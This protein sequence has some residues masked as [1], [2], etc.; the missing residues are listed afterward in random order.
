MAAPKPAMR[1]FNF[2]AKPGE[3]QPPPAAAPKP[4]D[5]PQPAQKPA[6]PPVPTYDGGYTA[7]ITALVKKEPPAVVAAPTHSV[8][9][10]PPSQPPPPTPVQPKEDVPPPVKHK[11]PVKAPKKTETPAPV[12]APP[13]PPA[14]PEPEPKPTTPKPANGVKRKQKPPKRDDTSKGENIRASVISDQRADDPPGAH[15]TRIKSEILKIEREEYFAAGME[16][17]VL[18]AAVR[19]ASFSTKEAMVEE[20]LKSASS[21]PFRYGSNNVA[22]GISDSFLC[23]FFTHMGSSTKSTVSRIPTLEALEASTADEIHAHSESATVA[24]STAPD[25]YLAYRALTKS[26]NLSLT[27]LEQVEIGTLRQLGKAF[28]SVGR[29][30]GPAVKRNA[31]EASENGTSKKGKGKKKVKSEAEQREEVEKKNQISQKQLEILMG[32]YRDRLCA[33]IPEAYS[34]FTEQILAE[35]DKVQMLN[36]LLHQDLEPGYNLSRIA[37]AEEEMCTHRLKDEQAKAKRKAINGTDDATPAPEK[38][39]S[40]SVKRGRVADPVYTAPS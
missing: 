10:T 30:G 17:K 29:T 19:P 3:V 36:Y 31:P 2:S 21:L 32:A 35:A 27:P 26:S 11:P 34:R 8:V 37:D 5:P 1:Q 39:K 12:Q 18:E 15:K 33:S 14:V 38:K 24:R 16:F 4:K 22:R 6:L 23:E 25:L 40:S 9:V 28:S 20:V 7:A 13:S